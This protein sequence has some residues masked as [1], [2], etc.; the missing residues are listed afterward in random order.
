MRL[1]YAPFAD[2]VSPAHNVRE[3]ANCRQVAAHWGA[4]RKDID[5]NMNST[6]ISQLG[7]WR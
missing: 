6:I 5:K 3:A 4:S 7:G 2:Q 1:I